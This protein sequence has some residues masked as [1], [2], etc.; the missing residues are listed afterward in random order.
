MGRRISAGAL[1]GVLAALTFWA[2]TGVG[3]AASYEFLAAPAK[4]LNRVY[5]LDRATGRGRGLPI[6]PQGRQCG[7]DALLSDG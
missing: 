1:R 6:R 4:D 2:A 3:M 5:R 7:R